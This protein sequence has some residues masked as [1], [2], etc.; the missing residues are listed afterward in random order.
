MGILEELGHFWLPETPDRSV[1]GI[2]RFDPEDGGRLDLIDKP[3]EGVLPFGRHPGMYRILGIAAGKAY[4]LED[5]FQTRRQ[6]RMNGPLEERFYVNRILEGAHF[7]P[8]EAFEFIGASTGLKN[9]AYWMQLSGLKESWESTDSHGKPN[10]ISVELTQLDDLLVEMIG[11]RIAIRHTWSIRGDTTLERN[12]G[13]NFSVGVELHRITPLSELMDILGDIQDLV[14]IGVGRTAAFDQV[15]L[16]HPDVTRKDSTG[17]G[18]PIPLSLIASWQAKEKSYNN[19]PAPS[20]MPFTFNHID[21]TA[22]LRRWMGKAAERR[23]LL[24]T[25]M[26]TRYSEKMYA[27]DRLLNRVAA[28]EALHRQC[29]HPGQMPLRVRLEELASYAGEPFIGQAGNVS[30]W[31]QVVKNE[32]NNVAHHLGRNAHIN[33]GTIHYLAESSYWLFVI[34]FLRECQMPQ[35]VFDSIGEH[36]EFNW[37][38][39]KL[40]DV[41]S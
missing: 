3:G 28:L 14:S 34:C 1:P 31:C 24:G 41:L 22:G 17:A 40:I 4:T 8:G 35:A 27:S 25:V 33:Q 10:K 16:Y 11:G 21:G 6:I 13:Q 19:P 20:E 12:I 2:L 5:C 18:I 38:K 30:R 23:G 15:H 9:L 32:R 36:S 39:T 37:I 7:E 26:G 29:F